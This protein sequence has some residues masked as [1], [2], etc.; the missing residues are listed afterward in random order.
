[1]NLI[2]VSILL[3]S[4]LSLLLAVEQKVV[5]YWPNWH[6]H[7]KAPFQNTPEDIDASLCTHIHYSFAI[8][9]EQ[10]ATPKD[11]NGSPQVELYK[12][13]SALKQKNKNLKLILSLGQRLT[14]LTI[15]NWI[16]TRSFSYLLILLVMQ[17]YS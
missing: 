15:N 12:R 14:M 16:L 1:M 4:E 9:D 13:L 3:C 5:C 7:S 10:H 17:K 8:L 11:S 6:L 2:F